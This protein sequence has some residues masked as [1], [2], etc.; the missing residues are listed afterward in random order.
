MLEKIDQ[1]LHLHILEFD[2]QYYLILRHL[3]NHHAL[4]VL[5]VEIILRDSGKRD[6]LNISEF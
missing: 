5:L 4:T 1:R 3:A 6:M 2:V